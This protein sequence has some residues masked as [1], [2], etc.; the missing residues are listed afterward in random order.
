MLAISVFVWF[1]IAENQ[2]EK[3]F[4]LDIALGL[5][6]VALVCCRRRWP[7][8]GAVST[9]LLSAVSSLAAGRA[10]L[11]AVSLATRRRWLQVVIIGVLSVAAAQILYEVQPPTSE[12]PEWL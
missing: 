5:P 7:M 6:A 9:A 4:L 11:A 12:D 2:T 3:W 8:Q 10:T 1:A